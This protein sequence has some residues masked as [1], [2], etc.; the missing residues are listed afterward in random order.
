MQGYM[1]NP[2]F[3][4]FSGYP[5]GGWIAK[6]GTFSARPPLNGQKASESLHHANNKN[7]HYFGG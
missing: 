6:N 1:G 4:A 2:G 5:G 7:G 3:Y